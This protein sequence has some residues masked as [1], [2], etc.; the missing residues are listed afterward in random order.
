MSKEAPQTE[1]AAALKRRVGELRNELIRLGPLLRGSL[2]V[3]GTR[4][5]QPYFS[6]N[7]KG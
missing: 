7:I 4:N 1:D 5:K 2:V 6:A 3:I